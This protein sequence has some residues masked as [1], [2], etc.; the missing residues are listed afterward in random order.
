MKKVTVNLLAL[1][2]L[3]ATSC[4]KSMTEPQT[5]LSP[6]LQ[7]F[8]SLA[9]EYGFILIPAPQQS[10]AKGGGTPV[11]SIDSAINMIRLI[12]EDIS[13]PRKASVGTP[14]PM[15]EQKRHEAYLLTIKDSVSRGDSSVFRFALPRYS[16][17]LYWDDNGSNHFI[18]FSYSM[19]GGGFPIDMSVSTGLWGSGIYSSY[20]QTSSWTSS[21]EPYYGQSTVY[22]NANGTENSTWNWGGGNYYNTQNPY[23]NGYITINPDGSYT[24]MQSTLEYPN[25]KNPRI[26]QPENPPLMPTH[27]TENKF[28]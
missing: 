16:V 23:Y 17:T 14:P 4:N 21:P 9:N 27:Q 24:Y 15:A 13:T 3:G 11:I 25:P 19:D 28:L 22:F 5:D 7:E 26:D 18:T 1:I 2:L 10:S 12:R 20:S 8:Y 6:K